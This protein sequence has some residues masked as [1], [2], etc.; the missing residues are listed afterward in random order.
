VVLGQLHCLVLPHHIDPAVADMGDERA[1]SSVQRADKW[2]HAAFLAFLL[3]AFED[4]HTSLLRGVSNGAEDVLRCD[5]FLVRVYASSRSLRASSA[6]R[7]SVTAICD[8]TLARGVAAH[9]VSD[10][11]KR[12]LS[13]R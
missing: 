9:P 10:D 5:A 6:L 4:G 11:E 1:R 13:C 8:A 7:K 3:P 12:Q 2:C